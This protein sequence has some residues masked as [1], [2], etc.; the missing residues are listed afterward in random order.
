M[1]LQNPYEI[2]GAYADGR[3][4]GKVESAP[5]VFTQPEPDHLRPYIERFLREEIVLHGRILSMEER[6]RGGC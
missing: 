5:M 2:G 4:I 3:P 6:S 1:L